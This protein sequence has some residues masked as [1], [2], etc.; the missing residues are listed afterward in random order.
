VTCDFGLWRRRRRRRRRRR[1]VSSLSSRSEQRGG[2]AVRTSRSRG[3]TRYV[4]VGVTL[5]SL[6]LSRRSPLSWASLA[7]VRS[8]RYHR[9]ENLLSPPW[10]FLDFL[11][12]SL[13]NV[14]PSTASF[15]CV[16]PT[17]TMEFYNLAGV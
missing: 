3:S 10:I 6:S 7:V 8:L 12:V 16:L 15:D 13:S 4:G 5:S 14:T 17:F 1:Q 9:D 2:K 11:L